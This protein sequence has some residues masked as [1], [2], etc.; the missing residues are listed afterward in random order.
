VRVWDEIRQE[1]E[2][3]RAHFAGEIASLRAEIA[4]LRVAQQAATPEAPPADTEPVA[5]QPA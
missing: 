4:E 1:L 2:K 3:A 5:G